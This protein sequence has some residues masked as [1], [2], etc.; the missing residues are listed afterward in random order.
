MM[1]HASMLELARS[2]KFGPLRHG[3]THDELRELLGSPPLWGT[4]QTEDRARIWRYGDIEFHFEAWAVSFIFSHHKNMTDGGPTMTIDPWT[5]RR[6][7]P[8]HEFERHLAQHG[9]NFTVA[10]WQYDT[11]QQHITTD[12][13][14]VFSF[15][16][17]PEEE[18]DQ[19]G[20]V[21]W[22]TRKQAEQSG[23]REPQPTRVVKS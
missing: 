8:R 1:I 23:E 5:V 10:R 14:V 6:G 13:G 21:W 19:S 20:L 12:S 2:G 3:M 11:S 9:V 18:W 16:V 17:E 7:L 15:V 4:Q 22:S